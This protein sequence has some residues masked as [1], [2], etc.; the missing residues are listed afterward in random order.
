MY[1]IG[2]IVLV[3][4]LKKIVISY[5]NDMVLPY[6]LILWTSY[7]KENQYIIFKYYTTILK[8]GYTNL[9]YSSLF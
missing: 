7:T 9:V 3:Y 5:Q 8:L 1:S 4:N 6:I 2:P